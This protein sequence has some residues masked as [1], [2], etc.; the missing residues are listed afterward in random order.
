MEFAG[1]PCSATGVIELYGEL[2]DGIVADEA[3]ER[4]PGAPVLPSLEVAT[5][6]DDA[7]SRVRLATETVAFAESL[8]A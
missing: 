4:A 5:R 3:I 8:L 7:E 6:M 2:L 1:V